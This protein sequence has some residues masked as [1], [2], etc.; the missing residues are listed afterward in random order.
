MRATRMPCTCFNE[1]EASLPRNRHRRQ[2]GAKENT[3]FN[4]AE[5]SLPRN[6]AGFPFFCVSR[7]QASMRPRQACLGIADRAGRRRGRFAGFNEAE[8]SLPRNQENIRRPLGGRWHASMRPRQA[9]LGINCLKVYLSS[10]VN[11]SMRPR[12]ACLGIVGAR[13][14][15]IEDGERFNEAEASLPRNP[16]AASLAV[17]ISVSASM[18]PR[19]ACLGIPSRIADARQRRRQLQ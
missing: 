18:R 5:A 14:V 19:Q 7:V 15:V 3:R 6:P 12:Q 17:G 4:E 1:A 9:C 8:A 11:A 2:Y 10:W 16:A 13:L